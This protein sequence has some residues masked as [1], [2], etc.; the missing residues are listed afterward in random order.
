MA[1][2]ELSFGNLTPENVG[3]RFCH[4]KPKM[5]SKSYGLSRKK[6]REERNKDVDNHDKEEERC[7][8]IAAHLL[9]V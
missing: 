9:H 6:R 7:Q 2:R 1:L 4:P 8:T 3:V 5:N